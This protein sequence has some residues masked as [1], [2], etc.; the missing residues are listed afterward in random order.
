MWQYWSLRELQE[1]IGYDNLEFLE[2]VIPELDESSRDGGFLSAKQKLVSLVSS[3]KDHD[4][5]RKKRNLVSSFYGVPPNIRSRFCAELGVV[6]A[7]TDDELANYLLA[8]KEAY[9]KFLDFFEL[10][11]RFL[12]QED[13]PRK[14]CFD[15]FPASKDMPKVITKPFKKLKF[16]QSDC[17]TRLQPILNTPSSRAILQMPTGSGKTRTAMEAIVDHLN[18][19][20]KKQ[21]VWLA[22]TRE[23]CEQAIQCFLEVWDYVGTCNVRVNR[24]WGDYI[25]QIEDFSGAE[26]SFSVVSL[27]GAWSILS[28]DENRFDYIFEQTSLTVVDEAH[29]AVAKTYASVVKRINHRTNCILLGLTATPGRTIES[30]VTELSELF[31]QQIVSLQDPNSTRNDT[32]AFLRSIGVMSKAIHYPIIYDSVQ[33]ISSGESKGLKEGKDFS[34]SFLKKLGDDPNRVVALV[35]KVVNLLDQG[36]KIILFA[37]SVNNS[38]LVSAILTFLGYKSVHISAKVS[39]SS[40]DSL[41][42][43]FVRGEYQILC[44]YGVLS[45]GFDAPSVDVVCIARPTKSAVLYSQMIGRGLRGKSVGG[46]EECLILEV[47]DNF[48]GHGVQSDLYKLFDDY[49]CQ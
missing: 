4:Y 41:I 2:V 37:P 5:F 24:I 17:I 46:T 30:E 7:I 31:F 18:S 43:K 49:W 32:I 8:D 23:L 15:S 29:I 40:R 9:L 47:V 25:S 26:K 10:D 11:S 6:D 36:A 48:V 34:E 21:V 44:N 35:K 45:T 39:P 42:G 12:A 38:F 1:E 19:E 13:A 28:K 20:G 27:Q 14:P 3:L 33:K 16:Y 22:N